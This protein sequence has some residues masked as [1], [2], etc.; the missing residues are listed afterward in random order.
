MDWTALIDPHSALFVLGGTALAT[1]LR[2]GRSELAATGAM[3]AQGFTRPFDYQ[4]ARADIAPEVSAILKDGVLR[5]RETRSR[6][7]ELI[8]ATHELIRH[9]SIAAMIEV[10]RRYRAKRQKARAQAVWTLNQAGELAPVFGMAGT[11][12]SLSQIP[13]GSMAAE[14]FLAAV[15]TA[16]V[17]TLYGLLF[18]HLM[19]LPLARW[20][21]RRGEQEED[22]RQRLIDW[23]ATQ[24]T[25]VCPETGRPQTEAA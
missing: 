23:L 14:G 1:L 10:H 19:F 6:D 13:A 20:V 18:A 22:E 5:A 15:A 17:T 4:K 7:L 8:D 11:L 21:A 25:P 16:I 12:F 24:L 3:I 2:S 9:R